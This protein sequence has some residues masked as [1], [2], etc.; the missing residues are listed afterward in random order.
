MTTYTKI[1]YEL[2]TKN[3]VPKIVLYALSKNKQSVL[4]KLDEAKAN[5]HVKEVKCECKRKGQ[6]GLKVSIIT[7]TKN[8][9]SYLVNNV[10]Q[11]PLIL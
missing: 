9:L 8:G 6:R 4:R 7:I 2:A 5:G 11:A 10:S 1:L 3:T